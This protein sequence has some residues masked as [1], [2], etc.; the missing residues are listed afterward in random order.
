MDFALKTAVETLTKMIKP[1]SAIL[2]VQ[3]ICMQ[4]PLLTVVSHIALQAITD[5]KQALILVSVL[6]PT[7]DAIPIS[8]TLSLETALPNVQ[9]GTGATLEIIP[10][11]KNV[12]QDCMDTKVAHKEL[13]TLLS[14]CQLLLLCSSVTQYQ[15]YSYQSAQK[16]QSSP[17]VTE[18]GNSVSRYACPT[19]QLHT[20]EIPILVS[21]S[22]FASCL[23]CIQQ[24][25]QLAY[26][27]LNASTKHSGIITLRFV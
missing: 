7:V 25:L 9:Q 4:I 27:R 6:Q 14:T 2:H 15:A 16:L 24:I 1:I 13:V 20:T 17:T 12:L 3:P 5:K 10:A 22:R 26:A 19:C 8:Q 21:V 11:I 18:T 23:L